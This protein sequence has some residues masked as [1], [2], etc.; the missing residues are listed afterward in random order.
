MSEEISIDDIVEIVDVEKKETKKKA[1]AKKKTTK[2]TSSTDK[3]SYL[4]IVESPAK[5]KTIEKYLGPD[6]KVVS[7]KGHIRDLSKSGK[8]RYGIDLE[9]WVPKYSNSKDKKD[10]ISDLKKA[11]KGKEVFLATDPD[12]EGEAISWHIAEILGLD[13]SLSNRIVFNEIN[14]DAVT[15]ALSNPRPIDMDMVHSQETR[16]MLDR[17][18]GFSLSTLLKSKIKSPSAGRVQSV[19][20]KLICDRQKEID[21]FVPEEYYTVEALFK[22]QGIEFE[23]SLTK[24]NNKKIELKNLEQATDVNKALN[25]EF[26]IKTITT[27]SKKTNPKPTFITSSLQQEAYAKLGFNSKKTMSIAQGLYE[28]IKMGKETQGL[29]TYMRTD[30]TRLSDA[31]VHETL[32]YIKNNFSKDHLGHYRVKNTAGAQDAHEGIRPT[33]INLTPASV[34][35]YLTDDQFK[36][37]ELIYCRTLA[38][39]MAPAVN[40]STS[41]NLENNGYEFVANGSVLVFDGYKKVYGK[42]ETST[43]TLLPKLEENQMIESIKVDLNQHFTKGPSAYTEPSLIKELED[44]KIGRPS[45]YASIIDTLKTRNYVTYESRKFAPTEQGIKTTTALDQ[46]FSSIINVNYTAEMEDDLDE[47]ADDKLEYKKVLDDF[48]LAYEPLLEKAKEEMEKEEAVPTGEMCP[49]CGSPMVY[50][51]GRFGTFEACS[52]YPECKHIKKDANIKEPEK[53]GETCPKCGSELVRRYSPRTKDY[54]VG[55]SNYPKCKYIQPTPD[56]IVEGESCPTCGKE[57]VIR[58]G[59]Y[60]K[61]KCCIDYPKCKTIIKDDKKGK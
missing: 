25:K 24:H 6:Y 36:V 58:Q 1:P 18:I 9:T 48:Y 38:S 2:K 42:F 8:G 56:E 35:Q 50:R 51:K 27:K 4:V 16:R 20:L 11:A 61:F 41:I 39:L 40:E 22:E 44:L 53:I 15:N 30:S 47:I 12:R 14:K 31:F 45:T 23:A 10:V 33:D 5:S 37:Y 13:E 3:A 49:E 60:G 43:D 32:A 54:F 46:F 55:C 59:R 52:N 26:L 19:A 7:S 17:I 57:V 28:G 34:K 21:A 29:I